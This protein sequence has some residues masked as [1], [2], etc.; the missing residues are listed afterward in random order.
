VREGRIPRIDAS[1]FSLKYWTDMKYYEVC[2][3]DAIYEYVESHIS[4]AASTN[5]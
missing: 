3:N 4:Q 2:T 1:D 5:P